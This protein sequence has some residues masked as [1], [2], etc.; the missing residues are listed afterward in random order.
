M[1]MCLV[2]NPKCQCDAVIEGVLESWQKKVLLKAVLCK[3]VMAA[4]VYH[5]CLQWNARVHR[6]HVKSE[7]AIVNSIK[8]DVKTRIEF[9][10]KVK[11]LLQNKVLC[12]FSFYNSSLKNQ[13]IKWWK[14]KLS[15]DAKHTSQSWD[16]H[17]LSYG[18]WKQSYKLW[19]S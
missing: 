19:K 1:C 2:K 17:I 5:I 14:Q 15:Y 11:L 18:W 8:W 7:D 13:R 9:C 6:G 3:L 12:V 16:S 10:K 4:T